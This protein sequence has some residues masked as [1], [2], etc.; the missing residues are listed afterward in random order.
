MSAPGRSANRS[1]ASIDRSAKAMLISS[2]NCSRTPPADFDVEPH[3]NWSA[4]SN[5]DIGDTGLGEMERRTGSHHAAADDHHL[6]A[7]GKGLVQRHT[8]SECDRSARSDPTRRRHDDA[9]L[10]RIIDVRTPTGA[11]RRRPVRCRDPR[12]A[13]RRWCELSTRRTVRS[14]RRPP[15]VACDSTAV[16]PP[17]RRA[18]VRRP[19]VRRRRRHRLQSV[20]DP[21]VTCRDRGPRS[22]TSSVR[23]KA[24]TRST[25]SITIGGDHT[26]AYALLKAV[27]SQVRQG[28]TGALRCAPRHMGRLL[29]RT[30][31]PRHAVSTCSGG[32]L[33]RHRCI[34]ACRHPRPDLLAVR[35]RRRRRVGLHD[36][37][38]RRHPTTRRGRGRPTN[39]SQGRRSPAVS[40]GRHRRARPRACARNWHAGDR[41]E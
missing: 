18:A 15:S 21:R 11:A 6:G 7:I 31:H 16:S 23:R 17:V 38:L 35:L 10:C 13:L 12:C 22:A 33:V 3:D 27:Q 37:Q 1:Y 26:I 2:E 29:R 9:S 28:R 25:A 41:R 14:H 8:V 36:D 24:R 19:A 40:V 20:L 5:N 39:S 32:R 4:S 34:D 30:L